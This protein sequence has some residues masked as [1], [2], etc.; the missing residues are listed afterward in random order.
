MGPQEESPLTHTE[1]EKAQLFGRFELEEYSGPS[2]GFGEDWTREQHIHRVAW[3]AQKGWSDP[4]IVTVGDFGEVDLDDGHHR[5]AAALFLGFER[6]L[7]AP[8]GPLDEI[9]KLI[10]MQQ[11]RPGAT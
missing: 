2:Y 11:S 8:Q 5:V 3:L 1:V 4:I 10:K 9:E 7:T 6:I